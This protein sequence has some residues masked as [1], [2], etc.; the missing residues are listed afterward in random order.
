MFSM[1]FFIP[2]PTVFI[3]VITYFFVRPYHFLLRAVVHW[4]DK[5]L[6]CVEVD[7]HHDVPVA[8][9][10]C[11]W[12]CACLVG[13]DGVREV[14]DAEENLMGFGDGCLVER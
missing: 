8:L 4:F 7:C 11:E 1:C 12:E 13:V 3:L 9:L 10:G 5:N 14:V 6:I 2:S